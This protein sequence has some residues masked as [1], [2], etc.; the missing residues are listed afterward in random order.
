MPTAN[1][2]PNGRGG[3]VIDA[4]DAGRPKD[5]R[6]AGAAM[7]AMSRHPLTGSSA[8]WSKKTG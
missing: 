6:S 8:T 7:A 2:K 4:T 1:Q 5:A 3:E